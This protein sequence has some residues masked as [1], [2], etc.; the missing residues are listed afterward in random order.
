L[1]SPL[2]PPSSPCP[3]NKHSPLPCI[4]LS[5]PSEIDRSTRKRSGDR[6]IDEMGDHQLMHAAPAMYNGGGAG[7]VSHGMW[8]NSNATAA[9]PAAA[10]ST[11]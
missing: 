1:A 2:S 6:Q 9:V 8:W 4:W 7:A 3:P 11:E 10:C 5:Y